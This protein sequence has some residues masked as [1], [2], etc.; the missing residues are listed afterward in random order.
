MPIVKIPYGSG[1][2]RAAGVMAK[3][4]TDFEDLRNVFLYDGK[5][6]ARS[7][8]IIADAGDYPIIGQNTI[9][10][11][12]PNRAISDGLI[13]TWNGISLTAYSITLAGINPVSVGVVGSPAL[14]GLQYALPIPIM[15]D[16][17]GLV[18][19]AHNEPN[20]NA[21]PIAMSE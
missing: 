2:E 7:G 13:V 17:E 16:S 1:L 5:A 20:I 11:I 19:I 9:A 14:A 8:Y 4:P 3:R 21:R 12:T 10:G 18:F 15:T 6:Q